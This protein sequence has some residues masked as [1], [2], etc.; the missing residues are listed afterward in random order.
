MKNFPIAL[1]TLILLI[2]LVVSAPSWADQTQLNFSSDYFIGQ[3]V[4]WLYKARADSEKIQR[5]PAQVVKLGSKQIQIKVQNKKN[6]F[7]NRW[8]SRDR[9]EVDKSE[10]F[11]QKS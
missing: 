9:L 2:N 7:I 3:K 1:M 8:V 5:I 6:E 11:L 4:T 10:N